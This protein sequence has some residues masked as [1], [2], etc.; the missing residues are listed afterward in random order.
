M[1]LRLAVGWG[2]IDRKFRALSNLESR[3]FAVH[4]TVFILNVWGDIF[5]T[6]LQEPSREARESIKG[7]SYQQHGPFTSCSD[8]CKSIFLQAMTSDD[9]YVLCSCHQALGHLWFETGPILAW[10]ALPKVHCRCGIPLHY[11]PSPHSPPMQL[12][13]FLGSQWNAD[14]A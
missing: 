13:C 14:E 10:A 4:F 3:V 9:E 11:N 6:Q 7:E 12:V 5:R 2:I 8:F 1:Y